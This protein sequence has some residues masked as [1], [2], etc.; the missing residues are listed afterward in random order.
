MVDR[1]KANLFALNLA[2]L[3]FLAECVV[4]AAVN[5][6]ITDGLTLLLMFPIIILLLINLFRWIF[7]DD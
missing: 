5:K 4:H 1:V 6:T 2:V 7:I 3:T